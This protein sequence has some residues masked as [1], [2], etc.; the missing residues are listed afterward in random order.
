[1]DGSILSQLAQAF[2]L[3]SCS[4]LSQG[5]WLPGMEY[6]WME[7]MDKQVYEKQT[8]QSDALQACWTSAPVVLLIVCWGFQ[9]HKQVCQSTPD[10]SPN[11]KGPSQDAAPIV[12]GTAIW[13][14]H[15]SCKVQTKAQ[16][17]FNSPMGSPASTGCRI[18]RSYSSSEGSS[19]GRL[20]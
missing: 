2:G 9:C 13:I 5:I 10:F 3:M 18:Y 11:C 20:T 15:C 6:R 12:G 4:W 14:L 7:N 17:S 16:G 19:L 1:M 8:S